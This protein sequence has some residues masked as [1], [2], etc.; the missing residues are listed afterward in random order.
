MYADGWEM[1][2]TIMWQDKRM[3]NNK[4]HETVQFVEDAKCEVCGFVAAAVGCNNCL[5]K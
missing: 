4:A 5:D 1:E 3:C 2:G